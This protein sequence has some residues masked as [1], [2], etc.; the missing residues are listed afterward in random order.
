MEARAKHFWVEH[1]IA[2]VAY[3]ANTWWVFARIAGSAFFWTEIPRDATCAVLCSQTCFLAKSKEKWVLMASFTAKYISLIW[4]TNSIRDWIQTGR[5]GEAEAG[6]ELDYLIRPD[7]V[8]C[9]TQARPKGGSMKGKSLSSSTNIM[10]PRWDQTG[11]RCFFIYLFF[12]SLF[13]FCACECVF[14]ST[15]ISLCSNCSKVGSNS[16]SYHCRHW[17]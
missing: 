12:L 10:G 17:G 2:N 15:N 5:H 11:G 13:P 4:K 1:R 6:S 14:I 8:C 16:R 9:L 7:M 3:N